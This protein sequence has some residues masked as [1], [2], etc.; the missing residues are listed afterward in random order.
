ME[1]HERTYSYATVELVSEMHD[2]QNKRALRAIVIIVV[3]SLL[4]FCVMNLVWLRLFNSFDYSGYEYMQDGNGVNMIIGDGSDVKYGTTRESTEA[5]TE[6][7]VES[8][9]NGGP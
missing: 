3:V 2:R 9:G 5:Y 1:E 4:L 8:E 7:Q 6:E